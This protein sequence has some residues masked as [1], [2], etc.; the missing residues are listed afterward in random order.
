M[1]VNVWHSPYVLVVLA[2]LL[3]GG[4]FVIGRGFAETMSPFTL[5]FIRWVVAFLFLLPFAKKELIAMK[6][7][8]K[9]EWKTLFWMS[10]TGIVGFNTILYI[11]VHYTTSI[12]AS[13][14]NAPTPALITLLSFIF[15]KE[16][17]TKRHIIGIILSIIG[18]VWIVSRGSLEA[19]L[20]F[21]INK[22]EI[23]MLLA[24]LSWSIYSVIV[25][26]HAH[27]FPQAGVFLVTIIIGIVILAPFS[28]YEWITNQPMNF[29][30][31]SIAGYLYVGIFASVIA[32]LSW[33]KAVAELGPGKASPFLNLIPVFAS[34]FAILFLDE[35]ITLAQ[36]IGGAIAIFGVLITTGVFARKPSNTSVALAADLTRQN[37]NQAN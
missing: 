28:A 20:S 22:G 26:K 35:K 33:N 1:V 15:L 24:I 5:A 27:K 36:I 2:T 25:K 18:I 6:G 29:S 7:F 8:W 34:I 3:W 30:L 21:S 14:I 9:K 32:F 13:L 19:L 17:V 37:T 11:A 31:P 10:L 16:T 23:W 4:N 12:N